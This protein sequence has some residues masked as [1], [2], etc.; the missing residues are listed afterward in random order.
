[1]VKTNNP[2]K[3]GTRVR[4]IMVQT[5]MRRCVEMRLVGKGKGNKERR[6]S[7]GPSWGVRWRGNAIG[8]S[9]RIPMGYGNS[10]DGLS[11]G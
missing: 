1:M 7:P 10:E 8:D 4:L 9:C 5:G 6:G 11:S 3:G 2:K